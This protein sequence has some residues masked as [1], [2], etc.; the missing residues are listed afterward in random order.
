MALSRCLPIP[1]S[2][3][4]SMMYFTI[5][6]KFSV[7]KDRSVVESKSLLIP[8]EARH[9]MRRSQIEKTFSIILILLIQIGCEY[10]TNNSILENRNSVDFISLNNS[11]RACIDIE[12]IVLGDILPGSEVFLH[13]VSNFNFSVV[14]FE[15]RNN[16]PAGKAYVKTS[17]TFNF[18]CLS[19]YLIPSIYFRKFKKMFIIFFA[20]Q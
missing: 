17:G 6:K 9:T 1:K 13:R 12:G 15:I 11:P 14:M 19:K 20:N 5:L 10:G 16:Q 18:T 2:E 7:S 4:I 8:N 3:I